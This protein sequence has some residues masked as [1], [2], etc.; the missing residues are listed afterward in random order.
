MTLSSLTEIVIL[1]INIAYVTSE[2]AKVALGLAIIV[3]R[4]FGGSLIFGFNYAYGIF[5]SRAF[6][7]KNQQK[8]QLYTIQGIFNLLVL[9][10]LTLLIT[11]TT[12]RTTLMMR[13]T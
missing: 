11:L 7:A 5:A 10:G 8:F 3:I 2:E 9:L 12:Y 13:Q 4:S 6:G 1:T